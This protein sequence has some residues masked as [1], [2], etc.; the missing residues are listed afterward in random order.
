M[1]EERHHSSLSDAVSI[2]ELLD[3][4]TGKDEHHEA[5]RDCPGL[6]EA[7]C[8]YKNAVLLLEKYHNQATQWSIFE[9][10]FHK[11]G[12][13]LK[14]KI[15]IMESIAVKRKEEYDFLYKMFT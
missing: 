13:R 15:K 2:E 12:R 4:I 3:I 5:L 10:I 9:M 6:Y 14:A 8:R 1:I 7:Y 11:F